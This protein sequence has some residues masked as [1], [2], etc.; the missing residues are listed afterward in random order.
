MSDSVLWHC[1]VENLLGGR[2]SI[3]RL[4]RSIPVV[5]IPEPSQPAPSAGWTPPPKRVKAV[6]SHRHGLK[7]LLDEVALAVVELTAQL[8]PSES[9]QIPTGVDEKLG[10]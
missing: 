9:G 4:I 7:Q 10:I 8:T 5:V 6:D 2:S 3:E 1:L